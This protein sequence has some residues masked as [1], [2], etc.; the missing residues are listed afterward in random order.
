MSLDS[1]F[2]NTA[3]LERSA[4]TSDTSGGIVRS[5]WTEIAAAVP[6]QMEDAKSETK[7]IYAVD[8][9]VVTHTWLTQ[10]SDGYKGDR[11]L[12][13]DGRY[14]VIEGV[15]KRRGKGSIPTFYLYDCKEVRPGA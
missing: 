2:T 3:T 6:G 15:R 1:M 5:P 10:N 13:D 12:S 14:M 9:I 8:N 7:R 11:W 4:K